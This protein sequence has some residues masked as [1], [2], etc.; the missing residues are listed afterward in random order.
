MT[1]R[2]KNDKP[3]ILKYKIT[4]D[5]LAVATKHMMTSLFL[6]SLNHVTR[7]LLRILRPHPP[8]LLPLSLL[9]HPCF[10]IK[11]WNTLS[12][13]HGPFA[14]V[15]A[16]TQLSVVRVSSGRI[17]FEDLEEIRKV[18]TRHEDDTWAAR[19]LGLVQRCS[20]RGTA[21]REQRK[22]GIRRHT[23]VDARR[24]SFC[25]PR[26]LSLSFSLLLSGP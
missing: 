17:R 6:F 11:G 20:V 10:Y 8:L 26:S 21:S 7:H 2:H 12:I 24:H 13:N 15:Y 18:N 25:F 4:S 5:S 1:A 23:C 9:M 22:G 14:I 19:W 3:G 16:V